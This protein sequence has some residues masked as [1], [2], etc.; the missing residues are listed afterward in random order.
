MYSILLKKELILTQFSFKE[1]FFFSFNSFSEKCTQNY[2]IVDFAN[3]ASRLEYIN[4]KCR[5]VS[6][7]GKFEKLR[8]IA[9]L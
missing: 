9:Q 2:V 8:E 7:R 1:F 3:F 5:Q 6:K 4:L